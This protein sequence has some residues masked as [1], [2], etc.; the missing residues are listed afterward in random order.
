MKLIDLLN[1][2]AN[3]EIERGTKI[4]FENEEYLYDY[5]N[6][7]GI[8]R[9]GGGT[10]F[11]DSLFFR[12][13]ARSLNSEIETVEKTDIDSIEELHL[14]KDYQLSSSV[15]WEIQDKIN[16][17]LKAIKQLNKKIKEKE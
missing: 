6:L 12:I 14:E 1:K 8:Y 2:I 17:I 11:T 4:K 10:A 9:V 3:G 16:E 7:C 5:P 13:D 15:D